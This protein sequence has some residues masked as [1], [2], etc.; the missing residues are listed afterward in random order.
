MEQKITDN[1]EIKP[2]SIPISTQMYIKTKVSELSED[3]CLELFNIIKKKT[4]NYT[5]NKNGVF[6][7]LKNLS[8]D[9][10]MDIKQYVDYID[11]INKKLDEDRF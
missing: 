10:L 11:T 5:I 6:I 3:H 2:N 7:N 9:L 8:D 1:E 4:D